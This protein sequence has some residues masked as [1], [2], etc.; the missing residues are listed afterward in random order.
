MAIRKAR[1][2]VVGWPKRLAAAE[3]RRPETLMYLDDKKQRYPVKPGDCMSYQAAYSRALQQGETQ[4]A[5][6]A[7]KRAVRLNCQWAR[8]K[9]KGE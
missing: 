5:Q 7:L 1:K 4:I 3:K 9:G 8:P 6:K 2:S